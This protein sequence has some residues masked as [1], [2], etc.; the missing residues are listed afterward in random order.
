MNPTEQSIVDEIRASIDENPSRFVP[1]AQA[2][3]DLKKSGLWGYEH[4]V[5]GKKLYLFFKSSI[6]NVAPSSGI[7]DILAVLRA[8]RMLKHNKD[9]LMYSVRM[10]N[11]DSTKRFYA[12][13]AE[14]RY[15]G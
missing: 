15:D 6:G 11:S 2:Q 9:E 3:V 4:Q 8:T 5:D 1:L 7:Q 13:R 14:I 10:P 12:I